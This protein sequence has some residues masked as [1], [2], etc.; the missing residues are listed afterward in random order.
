MGAA[1]PII[2]VVGTVAGIAQNRAAISA[3]NRAIGLQAEANERAAS[4]RQMGVTLQTQQL[5]QQTELDRLQALAQYQ[6]ANQVYDIQALNRKLV[7]SQQLTNIDA[8]MAQ[9]LMTSVAQQYQALRDSYLNQ[10][11]VAQQRIAAN[12]EQAQV[13]SLTDRTNQEVVNALKQGDLQLASL[14]ARQAGQALD[15]SSTRA[16]NDSIMRQQDYEAMKQALASQATAGR[17]EQDDKF[18]EQYGDLLNRAIAAALASNTAETATAARATSASAD[19]TSEAIRQQQASS[20]RV[21]GLQRALLPTQ[22]DIALRQANIN[23]QYGQAALDNE[24]L[25]IS[26]QL[27]RDSAGLLASLRRPSFLS[28]ASSLAAVSIP[29]YAQIQTY[30]AANQKPKPTLYSGFPDLSSYG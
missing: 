19:V 7:A 13:Y 22:Y 8:N 21:E 25:A 2:G 14:Y 26:T 24:R 23:Q 17:V 15:G 1:A 6:Q 3:N 4:I 12:T 30:R 16:V 18:T 9:Q 5:Q 28:D 11:N 29:L 10:Q 27:S 20:D